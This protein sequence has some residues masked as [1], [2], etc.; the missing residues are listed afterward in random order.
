MNFVPSACVA[1]IC[2]EANVFMC[3]FSF[4]RIWKSMSLSYL[5]LHDFV[6]YDWYVVGGNSFHTNVPDRRK[7]KAVQ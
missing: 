1:L 6:F 4:K 5:C 7:Y 3:S 2:E